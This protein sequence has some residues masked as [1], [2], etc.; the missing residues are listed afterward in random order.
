MSYPWRARQ[1]LEH[2]FDLFTELHRIKLLLYA[3]TS[4]ACE[5]SCELQ[6]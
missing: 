4:Q 3:P 1:A 5:S 2:F 6:A